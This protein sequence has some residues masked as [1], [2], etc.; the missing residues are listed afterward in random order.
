MNQATNPLDPNSYQFFPSQ[1]SMPVYANTPNYMHPGAGPTSS[2]GNYTGAGNPNY[3]QPP[4]SQPS[5]ALP[6]YVPHP[7]M[8]PTMQPNYVN[9]KQ[10]PYPYAV[11]PQYP[12]Y[13]NQP[14]P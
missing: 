11:Q 3:G 9:A 12:N 6:N 5:P 13:P 4:M 8:P 7:Q 1:P 2:P 14:L 10:L